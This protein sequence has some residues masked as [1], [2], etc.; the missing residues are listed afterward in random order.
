MEQLL[1]TFDLTMLDAQMI[2]VWGVLFT[3]LWQLLSNLV[4]KRF[5]ALVELRDAATTG[6]KEDAQRKLEEASAITVKVED[7]LAEVR[8]AAMKQKL[9][10][11]SIARTQAQQIADDAE[12]KAHQ[13][14]EAA[15]GELKGRLAALRQ[16]LDKDTEEMARSVVLSLK[17]PAKIEAR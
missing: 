15:R 8:V 17:T 13:T 10:E 6:A 14:I 3:V 9:S 4:F 11:L 12:R 1:K 2:V 16:E 7:K 5:I